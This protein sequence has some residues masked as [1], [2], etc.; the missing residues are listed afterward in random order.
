MPDLARHFIREPDTETPERYARRVRQLTKIHAALPLLC[1]VGIALI[2]AWGKHFVTLAQRSNVETLTVAFFV[3]FF[4][5]LL[6]LSSR[7]F[8]GACRIAR[9][10]LLRGEPLAIERRKVAALGKPAS[11]PE[12]GLNVIVERGDL[13]GEHFEIPIEDAAGSMGRLRIDGARVT[14]LDAYNGGSQNMLAYFARH[15][16]RIVDARGGWQRAVDVVQWKSID[17]EESEQY[18]GMV[19]FARNLSRELGKK[20]LWPAV[21]L[22]AADCDELAR[23][24]RDICPAL[25]DE[26]FLPHWEY[27]AEHKL[28]IIPEPLGIVSLGRSEKRADPLATMGCALFVVAASVAVTVLFIVLP[29]WVPGK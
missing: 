8:V 5:Y 16:D 18:L 20:P 26:A 3:L 28:P 25:R 17:D 1:A 10:A 21:T 14:H 9:F 23:N 27:S 19:E 7:G 22:S 6:V 29:P 2:C 12:I 13:P 24:L 15:V 11:R 4:L